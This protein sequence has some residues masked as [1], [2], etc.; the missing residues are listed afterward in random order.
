[1]ERCITLDIACSIHYQAYHNFFQP[2]GSSVIYRLMTRIISDFCVCPLFYQ[3]QGCIG[4]LVIKETN[5]WSSSLIIRSIQIRSIL[6]QLSNYLF[7]PVPCNC[8]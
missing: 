2:V 7:I 5:Q 8:M 6:Y 1:M 4:T 3:K